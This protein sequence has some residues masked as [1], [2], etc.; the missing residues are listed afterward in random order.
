MFNFDPQAKHFRSLSNARSMRV[1]GLLLEMHDQ[2]TFDLRCDDSG[3]CL[4]CG[5]PNPPCSTTI[6]LRYSVDEIESLE[7]ANLIRRNNSGKVV[8]FLSRG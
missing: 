1:L 2:K 4:R 5:Y 6:E 3:V 7:H 8:D